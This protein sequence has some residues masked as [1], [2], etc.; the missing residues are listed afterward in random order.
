MT[1]TGIENPVSGQKLMTFPHLPKHLTKG[2]LTK[3][4]FMKM[5]EYLMKNKIFCT[6][7]Y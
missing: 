2:Y 6:V 1:V 4:Y 7:S 5:W 3:D